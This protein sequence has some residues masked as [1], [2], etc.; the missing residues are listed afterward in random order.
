[1]HFLLKD[2]CIQYE[3]LIIGNP[4]IYVRKFLLDFIEIYLIIG[5]R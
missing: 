5:E 4:I 2:L 3:S 1:M